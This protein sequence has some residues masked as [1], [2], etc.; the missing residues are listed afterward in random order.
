MIAGVRVGRLV[1]GDPE[2]M[3]Q[4]SNLARHHLFEFEA[5]EQVGLLF[6]GRRQEARFRR[7]ELGEEFS[8]LAKLDQARIRIVLKVTLREPAQAHEL[9]V[10]GRQKG[11]VGGNRIHAAPKIDQKL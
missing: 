1:A 10:V 2:L 5:P 3:E 11:E 8:E 4:F 6:V 9:H 7:R